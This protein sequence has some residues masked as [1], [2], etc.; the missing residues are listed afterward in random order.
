MEMSLHFLPILFDFKIN[1]PLEFS[2]NEGLINHGR[3]G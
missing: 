1:I 2:N 3:F